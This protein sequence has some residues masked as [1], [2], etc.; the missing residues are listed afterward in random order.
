MSPLTRIILGGLI[1]TVTRKGDQG[2]TPEE[3]KKAGWKSLPK[4]LR[5]GHEHEIRPRKDDYKG[6]FPNGFG[7]AHENVA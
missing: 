3:K 1:G 5:E 6:D 7:H 2:P 4:V